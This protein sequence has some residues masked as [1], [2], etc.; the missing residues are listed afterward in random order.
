MQISKVKQLG[1]NQKKSWEQKNQNDSLSS[2]KVRDKSIVKGSKELSVLMIFF[3]MTRNHKISSDK[4]GM[5]LLD[6][7]N[8]N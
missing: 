2:F 7:Q 6:F 8:E 5:K 4:Y 3:N 1:L